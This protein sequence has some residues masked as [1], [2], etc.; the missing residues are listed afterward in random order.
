MNGGNMNLPREEK[1]S[2]GFTLIEVLIASVLL[3]V[4]LVGVGLFFTNIVKQSDIVDDRTR[5]TEIARQGL[6]EV[7][8]QDVTTWPLGATTPVTIDKFSRYFDVTEVDPL[9]PTARNVECLVYWTSAAGPD[10]VSF[11]TLF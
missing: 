6:E 2:R 11:S 8:T 10:T 5:A 1:R 9:Y 3:A 7:R 4:L